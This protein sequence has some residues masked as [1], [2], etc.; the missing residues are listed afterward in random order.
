MKP[1]LSLYVSGQ[2]LALIPALILLVAGVTFG[3]D[4]PV[5]P[6]TPQRPVIDTYHGIKVTDEYRWLEDMTNPEVR[7]WNGKEDSLSRAFLEAIPDRDAIKR[8]LYQLY[9]NESSRYYGLKREG[10][11]IFCYKTQPPLQQPLLVLLESAN[12]PGNERVI[13]DVNKLDSTGGTTID[14]FVPSHDGKLVAVSLSEGGS[15][16]GT[17]HVYEVASGKEL[18]DVIPRVNGPTAGGSVAWAA[19]NSGFYYTRYPSPDERP[20][21]DLRFFQ[22]VYYH[23]LGTTIDKDTYSIGAD[24]PK[25]AEISL[26]TSPDGGYF[27]ATVANGDGGEF[28]HFLMGP[29]GV[30]KELTDFKDGITHAQF[31]EDN[32]LYL[33]SNQDAPYGKILRM[34]LNNPGLA[35]AK[36]IIPEGDGV[37]QK[38]VITPNYFL[39]ADLMGGTSEIH[40]YD[41]K[42]DS[43]WTAP[44]LPVSSVGGMLWIGGDTVLFAN[45]SYTQP[46][47]WYWYEIS[48]P[49]LSRT[50]LFVTSNADFNNVEVLREFAISK[51]GTKIPM[52]ILKPRS[53]PLDGNNPTILYG[54][55]GYGISLTPGFDPARS[56]WLNQG[57]IYVVAN[58]RGGGEYGEEWHKAG[59]LTNKQNVFDD[60]AA[61][62][63][64]LI[65]K[66]YTSPKRLAINGRSNGGLLMGAELTQH[67]DLFRAVVSGVGIYDMLRVELDPNGAFNVTEFGSVKDLEQYRALA[68]YSPYHHVVNGTS[69]PAVLF[70]TGENDGRV[71][72]ANSRKMTAALQ[73]ASNSG[74]PILLRTDSSAGH[75]VGST[76][77][78]RIE[79]DTDMFSF[80]FYELGVKYIN[81]KK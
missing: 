1:I 40:V 4:L 75:G 65:D 51:D 54:Y 30:W 76:L 34:P 10:G 11:L 44:I 37:V 8:R 80:I 27:L 14:F 49:R 45:S 36:V 15:E 70:M 62:A 22:Q 66:K 12:E 52:T 25:I 7:E 18:G 26:Q 31:G 63:Q 69:Y 64:Y 13:L 60:F 48:T 5:Y 24:F 32:A 79:R 41:R 16:L 46:E 58:L 29:S 81:D 57:G 38:F 28:A 78:Q 23:K 61:C 50:A 56:L 77:S 71:N 39:V 72:P 67:P 19:D 3:D 33:L 68:G 53:A 59:A 42:T 21:G 35:N 43:T 55:G 2:A 9:T 74:L 17:V 20:A 73:A 6:D 47:A